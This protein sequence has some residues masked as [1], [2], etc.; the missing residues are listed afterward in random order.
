V[1]AANSEVGESVLSI[2]IEGSPDIEWETSEQEAVLT[3]EEA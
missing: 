1:E 2:Q 3:I